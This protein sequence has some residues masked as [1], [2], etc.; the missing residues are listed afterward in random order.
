MESIIVVDHQISF[1]NLLQRFLSEKDYQVDTSTQPSDALAMI[2][3]QF[4]DFIICDYRMP[5]MEGREFFSKVSILSPLSKVIFISKDVNVKNVVEMIR[6]GACNY[7]SK[8]VNP[9]ELI[10]ALKNSCADLARDS[11]ICYEKVS[12]GPRSVDLPDYLAGK[13][14]KAM[15]IQ[16]KVE[17]VGPTNYS[18]II[19]GETG[20]GKESYARLIHH[21]SLRNEKPFI[22]IDCG[23]LSKELAGSEL[24]GHEKGAFTGALNRKKGIF[25]MAQGGT[26]FL[27]EIGNLSGEVQMALLRVL[28]ERKIRKIGGADEIPID[29]RFIVA[30][31]EDLF[32]KS[33][34]SNFR[35][36]LYYRL[37]EFIIRVP[38]LKE[39]AEDIDRFIDFFL[40]K[41]AIELGLSK[42]PKFSEEAMMLLMQY[43]WPGNIRELKNTVRRSCLFVNSNNIIQVEV[44]PDRIKRNSPSSIL[45]QQEKIY[46]ERNLKYFDKSSKTDLKTTAHLAETKKIK[47]VLQD[48]KFN[49]TKAAQVLNIHRKTLYSKL[50]SLDISF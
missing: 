40:Q 46:Q 22:A 31:N 2:K 48:V 30:T 16:Y 42:V 50:K 37:S 1:C 21:H 6:R 17:K 34:S 28:Q 9:D 33:Q 43:A 36:D 15:D 45:P 27:D 8:P 44:L 26:V 25:E 35:E 5:Q 47:E 32:S 38:S 11:T 14:P 7:L 12:K 49:K 10:E 23:C 41:T 39:R 4:Y 13:S 18:V 24:F 29:V 3:N 19:E 20:T